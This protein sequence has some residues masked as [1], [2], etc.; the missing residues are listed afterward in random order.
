MKNKQLNLTKSPHLRNNE[1]VLT[2]MGDVC[3]ALIP[4]VVMSTV[5]YGLRALILCAISSLT[6]YIADIFCLKL[7]GKKSR[8]NFSGIVTGLIIA[9]ILPATVPYY[10][11]VVAGLF[12][13]LIVK[14]PFGGLGN[15]IFNPACAGLSF[16]IICWP[17]MLTQYPNP[18]PF[19]NA[20]E[21]TG[22]VTAKV[23]PSLANALKETSLPFLVKDHRIPS[24]EIW[25]ILIG[26]YSGP[27]GTTFILVLIFCML[28]LL[29]RKTISWHIPVSFLGTAALFNLLF[30]RLHTYG[31]QMQVTPITSV[32]MEMAVGTMVFSSIFIATDPVTT[33]N[34]PKAKLL[35]G[36]GC[37]LL[38]MLFR[39]FG[40]FPEGIM[41]SMLI[42]N[43]IS[44]LLD[45]IFVK[46]YSI[47]KSINKLRKEFK[48][49][50][51][52]AEY[53]ED[54]EKM[55]IEKA[56]RKQ[57]RQLKSEAKQNITEKNN[58]KKIDETTLEFKLEKK[59]KQAENIKTI[60]TDNLPNKNNIKNIQDKKQN[61]KDISNVDSDIKENPS[62]DMLSPVDK[63]NNKRSN[64]KPISQAKNKANN[65]N[66]VKKP[67]IEHSQELSPEMQDII[68]K[69]KR[70]TDESDQSLDNNLFNS[71]SSFDLFNSTPEGDSSDYMN[72]SIYD[73][74]NEREGSGYK[75]K[76]DKLDF[77]RRDD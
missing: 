22:K 61:I 51:Q 17:S 32:I 19:S 24:D 69:I 59:K 40:P 38:T 33:P 53:I 70:G 31:A 36:F 66:K 47:K 58:I 30:P 8:G 20:I 6:C 44:G 1:T 28:L 75:S 46:K 60:K 64:I 49:Y 23:Y 35:F 48:G 72:T 68:N 77:D 29:V 43:S 55:H 2:M 74:P 41:F 5:Y 76:K 57:Q 13:I 45:K 21:I 26:N 4:L 54:V 11:P 12:A 27:M 56:K 16:V 65:K 62:K 15:N 10:V 18:K 34:I 50:K 63:K 37:G 3:L 9:L 7:Q 52:S 67:N 71:K 39:Y 73:L 14:H 42:M 25:N